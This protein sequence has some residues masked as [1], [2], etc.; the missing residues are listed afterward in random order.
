GFC[1]WLW[2]SLF[3]WVKKP[4]EV[5]V[6]TFGMS[7]C[8]RGHSYFSRILRPFP[9]TRSGSRVLN[10]YCLE[11]RWITAGGKLL[12][13]TPYLAGLDG[14]NLMWELLLWTASREPLPWRWPLKAAGIG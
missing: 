2:L 13:S 9:V 5:P 3:L 4:L 10:K 7:R 1:A 11:C 12:F 8:W 14:P 6:K